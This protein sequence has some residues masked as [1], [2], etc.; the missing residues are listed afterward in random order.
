MLRA[1]TKDYIYLCLFHFTA[2][3]R[4]ALSQVR[5]HRRTAIRGTGPYSLSICETIAGKLE[6][7]HDPVV[8]ITGRML[9]PVSTARP[10]CNPT[11]ASPASSL[12][13]E[14]AEADS[15]RA[16]NGHP[17]LSATDVKAEAQELDIYGHPIL[18]MEEFMDALSLFCCR[19]SKE[20]QCH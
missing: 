6:S 12:K 2:F 16:K 10:S 7:D 5:L 4:R 13:P 14:Q 15:F 8:M 18:G 20:S 3:R 11:S 1:S 17:E 19:T 9:A